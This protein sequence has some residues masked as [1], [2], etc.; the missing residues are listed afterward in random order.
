MLIYFWDRL[1][2]TSASF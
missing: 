1:L 2:G